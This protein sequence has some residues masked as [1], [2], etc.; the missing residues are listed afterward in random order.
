MTVF[1]PFPVTVSVD[2]EQDENNQTTRR[3]NDDDRL[4][5]P[6]IAYEIRKTLFHFLNYI[7]LLNL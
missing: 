4:V 2:D 1:L 6:D 5:T 3:Q 7:I